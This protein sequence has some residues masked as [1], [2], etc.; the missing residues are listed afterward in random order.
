MNIDKYFMLSVILVLSISPASNAGEK[1]KTVAVEDKSSVYQWLSGTKVRQVTMSKQ[2]F[3]EFTTSINQKS[4]LSKTFPNAVRVK[5]K[6]AAVKIWQVENIKDVPSTMRS[7]RSTD[8]DAKVSPVFYSE[9]G[10]MMALPGNVLVQFN[11]GMSSSEIEKWCTEN[12]YQ[13]A[14]ANRKNM[15]YYE[16]QTGAGLDAIETANAIYNS[17]MVRVAEPNWWI[18]MH[19]K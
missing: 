15:S 4:V 5:G 8:S 7:I 18:E 6:G 3:A 9:S 16:I 14:N 19:T 13:I 12:G 1:N 17:G 11:P 2:L 10:Q